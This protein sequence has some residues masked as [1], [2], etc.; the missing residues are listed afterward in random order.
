MPDAPTIMNGSESCKEDCEKKS[1]VRG[2]R[3]EVRGGPEGEVSSFEFTVF[4]WKGEG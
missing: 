3:S 1:E 4:G 2:Q